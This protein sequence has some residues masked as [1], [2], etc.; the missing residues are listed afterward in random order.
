MASLALAQQDWT[1]TALDNCKSETFLSINDIVFCLTASGFLP[2]KPDYFYKTLFLYENHSKLVFLLKNTLLFQLFLFFS[3]QL[4]LKQ[5]K[6]FKCLHYNVNICSFSFLSFYSLGNTLVGMLYKLLRDI[7]LL[8]YRTSCFVLH[9]S[10]FLLS[11]ENFSS[12]VF[13]STCFSLYTKLFLYFCNIL[14]VP[15]TAFLHSAKTYVTLSSFILN[16]TSFP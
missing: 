16:L 7:Y 3:F 8:P 13:I 12:Y 2:W 1:G 14:I 6:I 5:F 9:Y 10:S 15:S 4:F 11:F